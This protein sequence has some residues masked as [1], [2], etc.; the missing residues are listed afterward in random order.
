MRV[1]DLLRSKGNMV[2]T[3]SPDA[4]VAEAV[5]ALRQHSVGALVVST[6]GTTIVGIISERDVVRRLAIDGAAVMAQ[7]VRSI[8]TIDVATCDRH[9]SLDELMAQM[10][11]RRIRH[12]PVESGGQLDGIISIGDVVKARLAELEAEARHLSDYISTGR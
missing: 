10:T 4:T 3:I 9:A 8:M 6:D 2:A 1:N 5:D 12:L 11:E 7:S